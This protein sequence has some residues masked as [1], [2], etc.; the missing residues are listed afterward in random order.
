MSCTEYINLG[1]AVRYS[2]KGKENS[3]FGL[4]NIGIRKKMQLLSA[5]CQFF[6]K[7]SKMHRY[8]F[9]N[10]NQVMPQHS[11]RASPW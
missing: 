8:P 6:S 11:T 2:T 10:G 3:N 4:C 7:K 5:D 1:F 9:L